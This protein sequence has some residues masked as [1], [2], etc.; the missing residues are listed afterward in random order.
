MKRCI[1][2]LPVLFFILAVVTG[3]SK[4]DENP[5]GPGGDGMVR[6][7]GTA[8]GAGFQIT[9][10]PEGGTFKTPDEK[11]ELIFP[12]GA[13][14][15]TVTITI[16]KITNT[17]PTGLGDAWQFGNAPTLHQPVRARM[18]YADILEAMGRVKCALTIA[19]QGEDGIWRLQPGRFLDEEEEKV[20][21]RILH[22]RDLSLMEIVQLIAETG[23]VEPNGTVQLKMKTTI[24]F[25]SSYNDLSRF[26]EDFQ[27]G[28]LPVYEPFTL[29]AKLI[30]RWQLD[31]S[32]SGGNLD[33]NGSKATYRAPQT[34]GGM[35]TGVSTVTVHI[36]GMNCPFKTP[37]SHVSAPGYLRIQVGSKSYSFDDEDCD[38]TVFNGQVSIS[39]EG[40]FGMG[41]VHVHKDQPGDYQWSEG[42]VSSFFWFEPTD[43]SPHSVFMTYIED[44]TVISPGSIRLISVGNN[45][46]QQVVGVFAVNPAGRYNLEDDASHHSDVLVT[47]SFNLKIDD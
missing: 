16:Q 19:S 23:V 43:W 34:G 36:K 22:L 15:E 4:E 11:L 30:D 42:P 44:G 47:G 29:P 17:N 37:I 46:G 9:V 24:N 21:V 25:Q 5:T 38:V 10:T 35:G 2:C 14:S 18:H 28:E 32:G 26:W 20:E 33:A 41:G 7:R 3:C 13:V 27:S 8:V 12:A 6:P 40:T 1:K 45:V 39:W 31:Q